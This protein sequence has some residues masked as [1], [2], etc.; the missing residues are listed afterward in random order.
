MI[1]G[2]PRRDDLFE[3]SD[4][5]CTALQL[6]NHWQDVRRDILERDRIY[7]PRELIEIERFEERL[8]TT[9]RQG[10]A[11]DRQFFG[12][13]R[14]LVRACVERTWPLFEKGAGLGAK[15]G[16][17]TQPFVWL[18]LAGGT[19][20]LRSIEA[21]NCET[22][23]YRPRLSKTARLALVARAWLAARLRRGAST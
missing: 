15:L 7:I 1:A 3:L 9:A 22:V 14:I 23:L 20:V 8:V 16:P 13:S 19:R 17:Q 11:P 18:F 5:T 2:E 6:T 10:F 4:A 21:W 12:E